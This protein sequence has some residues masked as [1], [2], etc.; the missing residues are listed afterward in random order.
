MCAPTDRI[1][2]R[3]KFVV[4]SQP[5]PRRGQVTTPYNGYNVY[6]SFLTNNTPNIS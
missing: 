3:H 6:R 1:A 5:A 4:P 2:E